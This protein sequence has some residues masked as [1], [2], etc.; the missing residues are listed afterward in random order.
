MK[1]VDFGL[2]E[3]AGESMQDENP[4]FVLGTPA[5]ISPEQLRG[6]PPTDRSDQYGLGAVIYEG[7][8]AATLR[9]ALEGREVDIGGE[10][11]FT[12]YERSFSGSFAG[13][14]G[15]GATPKSREGMPDWRVFYRIA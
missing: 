15:P 10:D 1:L 2:A 4:E 3:L 9:V 13:N 5:Y 6:L 7:D 11:R 14:Y 8:P 12:R